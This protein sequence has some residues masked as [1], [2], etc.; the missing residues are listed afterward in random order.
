MKRAAMK[1]VPK[2][3]NFEQKQRRMDIAQEMLMTLN[4]DPDLLKNVITGVELW[5][6]GHD[7]ETKAQSFQWK[8]PEERKKH[9]K[10][11]QMWRFI[12]LFSSIAMEWWIM[13]PCHK[14]ETHRIV[15]RID[16]MKL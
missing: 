4:D 3:L 5:V 8:R 10:F 2:L 14:E 11:G 15:E 9:T 6:Y 12:S 1:I 13:N 16:E 7:M